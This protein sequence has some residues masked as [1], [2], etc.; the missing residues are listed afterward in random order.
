[1]Q[2]SGEINYDTRSVNGTVMELNS[3]EAFIDLE[4]LCSFE[5]IYKDRDGFL[6]TNAAGFF[7]SWR[8]TNVIYVLA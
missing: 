7:E 5:D 6:Q 1:M 2:G 8:Y 4:G 3:P